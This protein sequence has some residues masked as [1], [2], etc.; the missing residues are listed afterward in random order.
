MIVGDIIRGSSPEFPAPDMSST[1]KIAEREIG[2]TFS[3]CKPAFVFLE[4]PF[5]RDTE[6]GMLERAI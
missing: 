3:I 2:H 5:G 1:D 6:R 4:R